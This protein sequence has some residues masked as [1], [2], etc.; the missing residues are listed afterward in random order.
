MRIWNKIEINGWSFGNEFMEAKG[1]KLQGIPV[2]YQNFS[3]FFRQRRLYSMG[4]RFIYSTFRLIG[5]SLKYP[6]VGTW[7]DF[8]IALHITFKRYIIET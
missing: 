3:E 1:N 8:T 7:K 4:F 2:K 6:I 5:N